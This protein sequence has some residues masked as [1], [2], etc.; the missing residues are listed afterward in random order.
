MD[1]LLVIVR[2]GNYDSGDAPLSK[3]GV[4][5]VESLRNVINTFCIDNAKTAGNDWIT[6]IFFSFSHQK[7]VVQSVQEL[8][9]A[10]ED[11]IITSGTDDTERHDIRK[12]QEILKKVMGLAEWY[13]AD[14]IVIVAH[15]HMPAVITE[16]AHE[17]VTGKKMEQ[18]PYVSEACG[19]IVNMKTG[20]VVPVKHGIPNQKQI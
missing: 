20:K 16:T 14:V 11:V 5:Q 15:G 12:P 7:R 4:E 6:R 13:G 17:F 2:H 8:R 3:K 19:Y 18:L 1:K 9:S 10:G